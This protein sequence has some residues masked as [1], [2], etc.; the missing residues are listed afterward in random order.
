[1]TIAIGTDTVESARIAEAVMGQGPESWRR[2]D[3]WIILM[4]SF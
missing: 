3:T 2:L 1:M 4:L